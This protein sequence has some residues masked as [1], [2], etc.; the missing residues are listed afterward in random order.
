MSL[1]VE[2]DYFPYVWG[3]IFSVLEDI[4]LQ[5][6]RIDNPGAKLNTTIKSRFFN[7]A[8]TTPEQVYPTLERLKNSHM[9][10]LEK[11]RPA[12]YLSLSK[13]LAEL[14]SKISF[15]FPK[16]LNNEEQ[17]AFYLGYYHQAQERYKKK[18]E[19]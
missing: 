16:R 9:D 3:R 10:K 13:Q 12:L 18:E 6:A 7:A 17:V 1:N 5:S 4:Q 2:S 15:P 19:I 8:S 11:H 14:F